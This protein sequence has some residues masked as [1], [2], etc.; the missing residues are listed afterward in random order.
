MRRHDVFGGGGR[1]GS[2][3]AHGETELSLTLEGMEAS[4]VSLRDSGGLSG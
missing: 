3:T 2:S 1:L 4:L